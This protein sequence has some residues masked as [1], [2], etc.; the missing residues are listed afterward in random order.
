MKECDSCLTG[1]E[2]DVY[3]CPTC[4]ATLCRDCISKKETEY[5]EEIWC[6]Y[7]GSALE[8]IENE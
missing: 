1:I 6:P 8:K 7:C 5:G 4:E 2:G 3:Y